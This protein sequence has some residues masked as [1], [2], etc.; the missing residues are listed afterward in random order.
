MKY[1]ELIEKSIACCK[2]AVEYYEKGDMDMMIFFKKA[3]VGY[4]QKA[5]ALQ[6]G[7]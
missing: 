7:E 5:L 1:L 6:V 3:S 4:E 2:K